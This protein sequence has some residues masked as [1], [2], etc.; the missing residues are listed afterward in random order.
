MVFRSGQVGELLGRR[1]RRR[2]RHLEVQVGI[3]ARELYF[4]VLIE[5]SISFQRY[6]NFKHL[7]GKKCNPLHSQKEKTA[8]KNFLSPFA[9]RH[10][11]ILYV[12]A[13]IYRDSV[14]DQVSEWL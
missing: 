6:H 8:T 13:D 5:N 9:G 10:N 4:Q 14:Q 1:R 12:F 11:A 2:R 3:L 7:G